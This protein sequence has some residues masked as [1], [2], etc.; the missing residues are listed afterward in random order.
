VVCNHEI[1]V[2]PCCQ[3]EI[4]LEFAPDR[5]TPRDRASSA[6]AV[7]SLRGGNERDA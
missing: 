4:S 3:R 7:V 5:N 1:L 6:S 2:S